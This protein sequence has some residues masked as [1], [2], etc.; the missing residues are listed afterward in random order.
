[1]KTAFGLLLVLVSTL[2]IAESAKA[3]TLPRPSAIVDNGRVVYS[4]DPRCQALSGLQLG[5][6]A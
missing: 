5:G 2:A 6:G 4:S 1:M 3:Q